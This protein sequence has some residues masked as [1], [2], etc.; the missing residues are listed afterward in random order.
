MLIDYDA[1]ILECNKKVEE[2]L[3]ASKEEILFS[4]LYNIYACNAVDMGLT[5]KISERLILPLEFHCVKSDGTIVYYENSFSELNIG[6]EKYILIHSQDITVRKKFNKLIQ[7]K[8]SKLKK[9]N[10]HQAQMFL[11]ASHELNTP[12]NSVVGACS[13]LLHSDQSKFDER[14]R[15]LLNLIKNG[16]ERLEELIKILLDFSLLEA[17]T[18]ELT[19]KLCN[20]KD[21]I[22]NCIDDVFYL[23]KERGLDFRQNKLFDISLDLDKT[24][25]EQVIR[26]LLSNAVKNT[27]PPGFVEISLNEMESVV[28]IVISDSGVGI[29]SEE[30]SKLFKKY[31]K[32]KR[33]ELN[34]KTDGIGLGLYLSKQIIER[35][36]GT[37]FVSSLGRNQGSCFT[38]QLP[39]N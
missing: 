29:T 19:K 26:N 21:L 22:L 1:T 8:I 14:H 20:I 5:K 17:G 2:S 16:G 31:G 9:I 27:P 24:R 15:N 35:H 3:N 32:V 38:I 39:K 37:I 36:H 12:L 30:M 25:I 4:N 18:F 13:L 10:K 6:T 34:I 33:N 7:N 23:I 11:N 28:E